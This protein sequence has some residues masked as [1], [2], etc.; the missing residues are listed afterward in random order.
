L[1]DKTKEKALAE[2]MKNTYGTER[3]SQGII[4]NKISEPTTI[5]ET[6]FMACKLLRKFCKEEEPIGVIVVVT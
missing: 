4:I 5:L 2:E 1:H 6:K 3:G